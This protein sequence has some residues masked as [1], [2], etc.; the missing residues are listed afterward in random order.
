M[1]LGTS[2]QTNKHVMMMLKSEKKKW[3]QVNVV[4]GVNRKE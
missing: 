1:G 3:G 4:V 2:K